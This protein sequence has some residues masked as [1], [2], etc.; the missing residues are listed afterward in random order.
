VLAVA[1]GH[2]GVAAAC[3]DKG[4]RPYL[5]VG[6]RGGVAEHEEVT[7]PDVLSPEMGVP[8]GPACRVVLC[9]RVH[10]QHF[11]ERLADAASTP[12]RVMA[13]RSS[14][15]ISRRVLPIQSAVGC[16]PAPSS[17]DSSGTISSS[18]SRAGRASSREGTSGPGASCLRSSR[19]AN[20]ASIRC[21]AS[22][23]P[24]LP[25]SKMYMSRTSGQPPRPA[26]AATRPLHRPPLGVHGLQLPAASRPAR[27]CRRAVPIHACGAA[28]A[29]RSCTSGRLPRLRLTSSW[30]QM[31]SS[32]CVVGVVPG[33]WGSVPRSTTVGRSRVLWVGPR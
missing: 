13:N 7:G 6:V 17:V 30:R 23:A 28:R 33:R 16:W 31:S 15:S 25:S 9:R 4:F 27:S 2:V 29:G 20:P 19:R 32:S 21:C 1:E 14:V 26:Q 22:M 12:D 18:V 10:P 5:W 8:G 11:V 3:G 24:A